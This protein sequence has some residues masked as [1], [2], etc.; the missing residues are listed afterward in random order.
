MNSLL[1][2]C[3]LTVGSGA[4]ISNPV[5][6]QLTRAPAPEKTVPVTVETVAKG[7]EHP[8]GLQ[9]LPDGRMLVTERPGR[10]RLIDAKGVTS[11]PLAGLPTVAA[12][13]QGGL[14]DIA[15]APDF[16][17]S[18]SLHFC[19]SEPREG[20]TN[21]STVA[22]ARLVLDGKGGRLD[23][24]RVVFRQTPATTGGLHFGCRL[25]FA[26]DGRLFVALGER[27]QMKY[28]Q[29]LTR[30]WGK[31]VRI[32]ADGQVPKDN[33]FVGKSDALPEIW[34]WGH[35][36]PQSAA[37]EPESGQLWVVEHGPRGGDEVNIAK[38]GLNYGWPIVGYGIDYSGAKLHASATQDGMEPPIYYWVPS[39]APSGMAFY[40]SERE[41]SWKGNIFV[42]GLVSRALHRLVRDGDKLVAEE[43]LLKD[44]GDR[45]R[46]VRQ[47]PD[48]AVWV[49]T[50]EGNGKLLKIS[51]RTAK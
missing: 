18:N 1:K 25:A 21:G 23:D 3:A 50:D 48:G 44:A 17:T 2:L 36:N 27:F 4:F 19:Y 28:A 8:W 10:L 7:L 33:P 15:L 30:H 37:I 31:V 24:V 22:R 12:V 40:T 39:I 32:E 6:A 46:D 29:D 35:R 41:P 49:L 11:S 9:F 42:G 14:L 47:G 34:S 43:V 5:L 26:R 16:A 13:N 20:N 51:P 38:A 45:I